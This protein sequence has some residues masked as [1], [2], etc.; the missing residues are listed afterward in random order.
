MQTQKDHVEAYSFLIGRMT[1]ALVLGDASFLEVPARRA[2]IGLLIGLALAVLTALGF[3]VFGL[4]VPAHKPQIQLSPGTGVPIQSAT[5]RYLEHHPAS[6][7]PF[8]GP[9]W[10]G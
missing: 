5:Y 4:F 8:T 9:I 2:W 10:K 6:G 3:F 1:S 7:V